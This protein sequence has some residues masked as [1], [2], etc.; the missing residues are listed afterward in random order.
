[1]IS[2]RGAEYLPRRSSKK[3][4]CDVDPLQLKMESVSATHLPES[5]IP[6]PNNISRHALLRS[7]FIFGQVFT[8]TRMFLLN[9]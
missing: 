7:R 3:F 9:T 4:T 8:V 5:D 1:M 2:S 6:I